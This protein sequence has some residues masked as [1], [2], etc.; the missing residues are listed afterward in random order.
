[1]RVPGDLSVVGFDNTPEAA[2]TN[3]GLTTVDQFIDDMGYVATE[4]LISL[5]E[6]N[7][8]ESDVYKMPTQLIAR[9]SCCA[10][11]GNAP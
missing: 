5:I 1:M 2:Y 4:M 3:P 11:A 10:I 7:S 8:L 6:G 9:D